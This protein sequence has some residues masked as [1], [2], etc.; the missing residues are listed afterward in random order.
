MRLAIRAG[1]LID[2]TGQP[3]RRRALILIEGNRFTAVNAEEGSSTP[4]GWEVVDASRYTVLPGLI[5]CHVHLVGSGDPKDTAFGVGE[6][7]TSIPAATLN[8]YRNALKDLEVGWTTVRDAASRHFADIALRDAI[9]RGDLVGPRLWCC[10]LGI[11]STGGHMDREKYMAPHVSLP[12]P[13]AVADDPTEGRKA[14]RLNLRNN[15]DF[16]KIN[17]TLTEHVRRYFGYCAPEMTRETMAAIFQEA[18]WHGRKVTAHCYGG[19]GATWAIEEGIDGIEH[20]FYL[21]DTHLDMMA[22]R[23]TVLCPTL[24]VVGRF[25]EHGDAALPPGNP[26]LPAWRLKAIAHAWDTVR[27]A[28]ARGVKI[29][30]GTDAAMPFVYHGTNAYELEMLTEA[31]LSPLEAITAATGGAADAIDFKDV[32]SIVPTKLAD[33]VCVDG[34]PL[35]DIK[36]LQ[37]LRRIPLVVKDGR[38]VADRRP[39]EVPALASV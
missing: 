14:V 22:E 30:C 29:I 18:H 24:S 23:G 33:L 32:G 9:N 28:H 31:G 37:D 7:V 20:G 39:A 38:I 21:T 3:P 35:E 27:R 34:D 8:C 25:R 26:H 15:V 16:I 1:R 5:D 4:E 19:D 11:T 13:S 10:G 36:I 6:V 2:G 12:G 17:A